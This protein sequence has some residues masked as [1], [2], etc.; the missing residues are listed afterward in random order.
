MFDW[1]Y[2]W[3]LHLH[4]LIKKINLNG[5]KNVIQNYFAF[6]IISVKHDLILTFIIIVCTS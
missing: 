3:T 4:N 2:V 6:N 5:K 1:A